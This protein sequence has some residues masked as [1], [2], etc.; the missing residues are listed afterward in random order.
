M[1][2]LSIEYSL[3][4]TLLTQFSEYLTLVRYRAGAISIYITN[5][6]VGGVLQSERYLLLHL[7]ECCRQQPKGLNR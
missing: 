2:K 7:Y 1:R 6:H 4:S 5:N 3:L